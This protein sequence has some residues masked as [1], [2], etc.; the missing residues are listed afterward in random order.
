MLIKLPNDAILDGFEFTSE[1]EK[2]KWSK[3]FRNMARKENKKQPGKHKNQYLWEK[4]LETQL[5]CRGKNG[6]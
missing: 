6:V 1:G 4:I 3:K 2:I 5:F